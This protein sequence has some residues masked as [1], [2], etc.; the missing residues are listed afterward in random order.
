MES[1]L[2]L[3]HQFLKLKRASSLT[4]VFFVTDL[5]LISSNMKEKSSTSLC[6]SNW[7]N[8]SDCH[9]FVSL[10][11]IPSPFDH[12]HVVTTTTH[13]TL[14]AVRYWQYLLF[15]IIKLETPIMLVFIIITLVPCWSLHL[16]HFITGLKKFTIFIQLCKPQSHRLLAVLCTVPLMIG[17]SYQ[18]QWKT[19]LIFKTY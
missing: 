5:P 11:V 3:Q 19:L 8:L 4:I 2:S 1:G 18:M 12:S 15:I 13:K 9:Y 16:S 7:I 14:R 6:L 10:Q 17:T